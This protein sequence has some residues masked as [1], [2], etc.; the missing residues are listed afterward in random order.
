MNQGAL[1]K[2]L[3]EP[4]PQIV[5]P[6]DGLMDGNPCHTEGT[7]HPYAKFLSWGVLSFGDYPTTLNVHLLNYHE[8]SHDTIVSMLSQ[9]SF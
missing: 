7:Q 8:T 2:L 4:I 3:L 5:T 9:L 1:T 6:R